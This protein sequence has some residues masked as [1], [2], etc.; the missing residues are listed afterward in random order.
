MGNY[1]ELTK[2]LNDE[3]SKKQIV[4]DQLKINQEELEN[5]KASMVSTFSDPFI[6]LELTLF[7]IQN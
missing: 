1:E 5:E 7:R 2:Q 6:S 3:V 4:I